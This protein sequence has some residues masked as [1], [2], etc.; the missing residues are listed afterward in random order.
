MT[1]APSQS[2]K[3]LQ[4]SKSA[5]QDIHTQL[6]PFLSRLKEEND[7]HLKAQAQ[8]AVALS[9][10]T[11]RYIEARLKGKDEGRKAEDPLRQELNH[12][13]KILADIEKKG[14]AD[15]AKA[16]KERLQQ[17]SKVRV[18][19]TERTK[20][21]SEMTTTKTFSGETLGGEKRSSLSQTV[22][23]TQQKRRKL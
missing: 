14:M 21:L 1:M 16:Q 23:E 19:K 20:D 8:A 13:R 10:G 6:K 2:L 11:L 12:I 4:Q 15:A 9:I 18:P 5:I 7:G 17:N 3:S 22:P